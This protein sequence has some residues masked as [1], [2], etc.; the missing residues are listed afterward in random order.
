MVCCRYLDYLWL[1]VYQ[2]AWIHWISFQCRPLPN[3]WRWKRKRI[4]YNTIH[5]EPILRIL[6]RINNQCEDLNMN[7][8]TTRM[9]SSRMRTA[10]SLTVSH[11]ICHACLPPRMLPCH[12]S[13]HHTCPRHACSPTMHAPRHMCPLPHTP[14]YHARPPVEQNSWH[15]LLKILPCPKLRLRA[16]M[17]KIRIMLHADIYKW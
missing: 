14:P 7:L 13:P 8:F 10:R 3:S 15:T 9:H 11:G 6:H 16:V 12:T 2:I 17:R 5:L 1:E 4:S